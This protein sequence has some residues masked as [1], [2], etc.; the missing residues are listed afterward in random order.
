MNKHTAHVL[1]AAA[2]GVAL[3][4]AGLASSCAAAAAR[5]GSAAPPAA[6][7]GRLYGVAATSARSAWAVGLT[8]SR[9]LIVRWNGRA[10][11]Q[12]RSWPG[13][14]VTVAATSRRDA[15][16]VGGT[17]WFRAR[18]LIVHWNGR[19][20]K[21]VPSPSPGPASTFSG[22]AATSPRNAWAVG[23]TGTSP[24]SPI[25]PGTR[26]L[27][28]HWNGRA[29]RQVPSPSPGP[30]SVLNRV[31]AT[32]ARSAWAVGQ[33]GTDGP[34]MRSLILHWNGKA[35]KRARIPGLPAESVL[36][37]VTATSARS[38][39]A[40]GVTGVYINDKTLILHWNGKAWKRVPSPTPAPG[41][42]LL[43][44]AALSARSAWAVGNT[45]YQNN[46]APKCATVIERWNGST[47]KQIPSPNPASEYLNAL[48]AVAPTS[49]RNAWAVG[50]TD[51]ATTLITR[52]NGH[53]WK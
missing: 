15:W 12:A 46:C 3:T 42:T 29:W 8:G 18:T 16:A 9:T 32:S 7:S 26:T 47:W 31:A 11:K 34:G 14:L 45:Q 10:W 21:R 5:T 35:W 27:I 22:V 52:C 6:F 50:T 49:A 1:S 13:Y 36:L 23:E 4:A 25:A 38:A 37:A 41:A 48:F 51:Y 30:A 28:E 24:A 2:A 43:G 20:W 17:N 39:W 19:A 44:V 40:V 53:T 33:T